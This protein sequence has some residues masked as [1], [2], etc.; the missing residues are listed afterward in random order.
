MKPYPNFK[1]AELEAIQP[2][3]TPPHTIHE[4]NGPVTQINL[5]GIDFAS[6]PF[7]AVEKKEK[8]EK[9]ESPFGFVRLSEE[10]VSSRTLARAGGE[11]V[12]ALVKPV[13]DK[14]AQLLGT[15][16]LSPK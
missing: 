14:I 15:Q 9:N 16:N 1:I 13:M 5:D 3:L 7:I 10:D 12:K 2:D 11:T 8:I 4:V 6:L